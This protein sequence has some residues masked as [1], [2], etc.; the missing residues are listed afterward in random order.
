MDYKS[1]ESIL[2]RV[3]AEQV[4]ATCSFYFQVAPEEP[5]DLSPLSEKEAARFLEFT[6]RR[7]ASVSF[8]CSVA[9]HG[10]LPLQPAR[11]VR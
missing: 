3:C 10:R 5:F 2:L 7:H 8:V 1:S 6:Q 9:Y 4:D 11:A